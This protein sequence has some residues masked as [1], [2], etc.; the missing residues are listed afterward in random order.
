MLRLALLTSGLTGYLDA[1]LCALADRDVDMFVAAKMNRDNVAYRAFGIE[2]RAQIWPWVE[3]PD[4]DELVATVNEFRPDAVMMHSWEFR[5]YRAVMR[6]VRGKAVRVLWMDNPWR[7]TPRQWAARAISRAYLKPCFDVALVPSDRTEAFARRLGYPA[8]AV[9][10]G[11]LTANVPLFGADPVEGSELRRRARFM[12]VMRM[13]HHKG[14]DVL[15]EAYAKYR[16]L[17]SEPWDL[18][19]VGLG[20]LSSVFDAIP[21][22]RQHG[23]LQPPEVAALMRQ[24]SCYINPSRIEPYGVVLHEAAAAALPLLTSDL[25]G[26]A[27]TMVQDGYNGWIVESARTDLLA[28]AM[29]RVSTSDDDRLTEMS[30]ISRSISQRLSPTGWARNLHEDLQRRVD[31]LRSADA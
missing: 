4:P 22:V 11:S 19:V 30:A 3:D 23:F 13:V 6:S 17:V 28:E 10:R 25:V 15:A 26:A 7:E 2:S 29:A 14:P 1:T 24:A 12:S 27:P 21:G 20:P 5:P 8:S 16:T 9:I 18:D 31:A